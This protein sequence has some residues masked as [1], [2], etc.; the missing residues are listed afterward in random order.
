M[1]VHVSWN[2]CVVNELYTFE[3]K[4][5]SDEGAPR[6]MIFQRPLSWSPNMIS[7]SSD[8]SFL[9]LI[10]ALQKGFT[11]LLLLWVSW[12]G[13]C[14]G[15]ALATRPGGSPQLTS[16]QTLWLYKSGWTPAKHLQVMVPEQCCTPAALCWA[17]GENFAVHR[18]PSQHPETLSGTGFTLQ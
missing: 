14:Q 18:I 1:G 16:E 6:V 12:K 13:S 9:C 10:C 17:H 5:T 2:R 8:L 4:P 11:A 3:M 7:L 15:S